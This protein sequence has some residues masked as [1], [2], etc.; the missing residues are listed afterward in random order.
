MLPGTVCPPFMP[1]FSDAAGCLD[2][3]ASAAMAQLPSTQQSGSAQALAPQPPAQP[4]PTLS[5]PGFS[6]VPAKVVRKIVALEFVDMWELLPETWRLDSAVSNCCHDRRPRRGLITDISLW[7]ECFTTLAAVLSVRYPDKAPQLMAYLRTII[8]ASRNFEGAAWATYDMAF[9]RQAANRRSLDWGMTDPVLYNEAFTGRAKAIP[10]CK[11]CLSDSHAS[12][13][14]T[15]APEEPKQS[16]PFQPARSSTVPVAQ[17][18]RLFNKQGGSQCRY[19]HCRYA[20]LCARCNRPHPVADCDRRQ[21]T[22]R[23]RSPSPAVR[24]RGA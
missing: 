24:E 12:H 1:T 23:A 15:Y 21:P 3:L 7:T 6:A 16:R 13:D 8:R 18:C 10:R 20:H 14:C 2:S 11:Y 4:T 17:I 19:K 5:I 22:H 9:R